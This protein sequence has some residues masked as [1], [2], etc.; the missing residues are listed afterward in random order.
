MQLND[1]ISEKSGDYRYSFVWLYFRPLLLMTLMTITQ[2]LNDLN[3]STKARASDFSGKRFVDSPTKA[4]N[5][6]LTVSPCC[7]N[8]WRTASDEQHNTSL[9][10]V[11]PNA[12][13]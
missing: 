8:T 5:L 2:I 1:W 4:F 9:P 11:P 13:W 12:P 10:Y 6:F 7:I 3:L